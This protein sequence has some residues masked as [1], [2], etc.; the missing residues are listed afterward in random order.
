MRSAQAVSSKVSAF[1]GALSL[2]ILATGPQTRAQQALG[3]P[4]SLTDGNGHLVSSTSFKGKWLLVYF[5]YTHCADQCPFEIADMID[6]MRQMG[7]QAGNVQ[8]IFITIDPGR[9][10]GQYLADYV[11]QF[12]DRLIGLGGTPDQIAA[13]AS[14]YGI[15]YR[16][17]P[18]ENGGYSFK[19]SSEIFV[20]N[21]QGQYQVTF[22]HMSD[23][24]M[25]ASKLLEL[26][27]ST[28]RQ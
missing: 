10:R 22:S 3:A 6:A 8:P 13:L 12:D 17:I 4:F 9:D 7:A 28:D 1:V 27:S 21:P 18:T 19:H 24:Y 5:G 14:D 11:A 15:S 16:K 23:G 26:M 25:I 2:S 20:L